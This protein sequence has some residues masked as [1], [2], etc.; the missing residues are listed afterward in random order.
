[1]E[2]R[3]KEQ[4]LY[5]F[6]DRTSSA[7]MRANQLRLYF[8]SLAYVIMNELRKIALGGTE[9]ARAQC[10]TIRVKLLKIGAQVKVSIRR[11][12][13]SIS[14]GYPYQDMFFQAVRNLKKAYPQ[15]C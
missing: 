2:N 7:T 9:L 3:L 1:M 15:L 13:V 12:H 5:L 11:V 4:Q 10:H 8:S 6:A 14:T